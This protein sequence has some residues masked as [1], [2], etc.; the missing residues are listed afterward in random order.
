MDLHLA[1]SHIEMAR[2]EQKGISKTTTEE[3]HRTFEERWI[4]CETNI[5]NRQWSY[6][7][8]KCLLKG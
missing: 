2:K 3:G 6:V 7:F 1:E 5:P 4:S 8:D